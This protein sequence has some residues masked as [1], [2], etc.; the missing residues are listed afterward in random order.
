MRKKSVEK[1]CIEED[2]DLVTVSFRVV[3]EGGTVSDKNFEK[4]ATLDAAK[5]L[6]APIIE[7]I[8]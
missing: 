6:A 2:V 7:A 4:A 8:N 1:V 3:V 5:A